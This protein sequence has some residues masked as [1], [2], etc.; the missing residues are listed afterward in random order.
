MG[1]RRY[2]KRVRWGSDGYDLAGN[3]GILP[4][5]C[6]PHSSRLPKE[7]GSRDSDGEWEVKWELAVH[8]IPEDSRRVLSSPEQLRSKL[9]R[10]KWAERL[11]V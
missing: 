3:P 1:P 11:F 6:S 10:P 7:I 5:S 9:P 8:P 4:Q 2:R